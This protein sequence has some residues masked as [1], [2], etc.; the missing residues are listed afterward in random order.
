[1]KIDEGRVI[2]QKDRDFGE[3]FAGM[4]SFIRQEF[5][6]LFKPILYWCGPP[7]LIGGI[8]M[9]FLMGDFLA[10]ASDIDTFAGPVFVDTMVK[11][12]ITVLVYAAASM[13]LSL[14][15]HSYI[16]IYADTG[17]SPTLDEL[18]P[19]MKN[20][21]LPFIGYGFVLTIILAIGFFALIFPGVYLLVSLSIVFMI[22]TMEGPGLSASMKRSFNLVGGNWWFVFG[23]LIVLALLMYFLSAA[24]QMPANVAMWIAMLLNIGKAATY[25]FDPSGWT[26]VIFMIAINISMLVQIFLSVLSI[27]FVAFVYFRLVEQKESPGLIARVEK[28]GEPAHASSD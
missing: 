24:M 10:L 2:F 17:K 3:L 11:Y 14:I 13:L 1:M 18:K 27:V 4:F 26:S 12:S 5:K 25:A 28:L 23:A 15:V 22:R 16:K 21:A 19:V 6:P 8:V 7:V 9:S 20:L